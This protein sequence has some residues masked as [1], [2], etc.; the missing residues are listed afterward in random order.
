MVAGG[1]E[2]KEVAY[3][4]SH[5]F[6]I[7][8]SAS[9]WALPFKMFVY[10]LLFSRKSNFSSKRAVIMSLVEVEFKEGIRSERNKI[11]GIIHWD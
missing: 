1:Y 5:L 3:N 4:V 9:R 8:S 6:S 7:S 11:M 10:S 2:G